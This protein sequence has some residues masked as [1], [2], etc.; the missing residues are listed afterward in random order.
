MKKAVL[1]LVVSSIAITACSTTSRE[2]RQKKLYDQVS[3]AFKV[4]VINDCSYSGKGVAITDFRPFFSDDSVKKS[5]YETRD[6]YLARMKAKVPEYMTF[7]VPAKYGQYNA[8][9]GMLHVVVTRYAEPQGLQVESYEEQLR[10]EKQEA[11]G[12]HVFY[13]A[14]NLYAKTRSYPRVALKSEIPYSTQKIGQTAYGYEKEYTAALY[15]EYFASLGMLDSKNGVNEVNYYADIPMTGYE[16]QNAKDSL[17]I[18]FTIKAVAPYLLS[19]DKEPI[20]A[21]ISEPYAITRFQHVFVGDLCSS[22]FVD[23]KSGKTYNVPLQ[24]NLPKLDYP[25]F[26]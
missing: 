14:R 11:S 20:A 12:Y 22:S 3:E 10:K 7:R 25:Y 1:V 16:A 8:E 24:L 19:Y 6:Q 17:E 5:E 26:R 21:T 15:D 13:A 18:E 2:E 4:N 23:S 9:T